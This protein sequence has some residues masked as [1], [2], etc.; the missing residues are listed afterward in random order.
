MNTN[1]LSPTQLLTVTLAEFQSAGEAF[2]SALL[3][4]YGTDI[5]P[6]EVR[7]RRFHGVPAIDDAATRYAKAA[8]AWRDAYRSALSSVGKKVA[9]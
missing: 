1:E 7:Y 3:A 4:Y 2:D 6:G 9:P 8:D 5:H